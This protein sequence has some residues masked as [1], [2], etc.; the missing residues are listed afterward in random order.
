MQASSAS[1]AARLPRGPHKLSR[2][3]VADSQRARLTEAVTELL[4]EGGW[5]AVTIGALA[6]RAGVSRAAFYEHFATKEA[7]LLAAYDDFMVMVRQAMFDAVPGDLAW[8]AFI[9][10]TLTGYLETME[11]HPVE[12]RAFVVEMD[13]AGA[14]A[15][16][17]RRQAVHGF[18]ALL[19]HRH[20]EIRGR[21]P[22][23]GPLPERVYLGL[24]LAVRE[25]VHESLEGNPAPALSELAPDIVLWITATVEG[26]AA[27]QYRPST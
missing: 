2:A 5:P 27:A 4:A 7:C 19:A 11:R 24:A 25:L 23:L 12:A 10:A 22:R 9:E 26:A 15:Q 16:L 17:R 20:A 1:S 21:E 3:E 14:T 8:E 13:A 6:R 18:A